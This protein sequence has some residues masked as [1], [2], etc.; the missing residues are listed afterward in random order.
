MNL[1]EHLM[2]L[3]C[4][5]IMTTGKEII[6]IHYEL[7]RRLEEELIKN[8]INYGV[9]P[10]PYFIE[11]DGGEYIQPELTFEKVELDDNKIGIKTNYPKNTI[12]TKTICIKWT[13]EVDGYN[14]DEYM[15]YSISEFINEID[16]NKKLLVYSCNIHKYCNNVNHE[17]GEPIEVS[18]EELETRYIIKFRSVEV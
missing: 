9:S 3:Y 7:F 8:N 1:Q 10:F 13:D 4:K 17:T 14:L 5:E 11:V 6:S 16:R 18:D 15:D 2:K 12:K